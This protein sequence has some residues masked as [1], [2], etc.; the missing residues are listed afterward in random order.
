MT[1][2]LK[3][4][5]IEWIVLIGVILILFNT[6]LGTTIASTLQRGLLATGLITP[7]IISEEHA[8]TADYEFS[9]KNLQTQEQISFSQLKG[10][11]IFVNFWATWCAPCVAELP[12]IQSLYDDYK[13]DPNVS[14][15][16]VT[17]DD[18]ESKAKNFFTKK[19]LDMPIYSL[20]SGLPD[21]YK[22]SSIPTTYVISP[23][24]KILV[25]RHG[26]AKYNTSS[27]RKLLSNQE[28]L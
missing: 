5:I 26:I 18:S 23:S 21:S 2:K 16:M 27:F 11:T 20:Q 25:E 15:V 3:R 7:S 1:K 17:F 13:D 24:G 8:E 12:D 22:T 6:S 10:K 19:E 28:D 14:F 4:E 9:L